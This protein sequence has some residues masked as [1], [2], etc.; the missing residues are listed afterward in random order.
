MKRIAI[1]LGH[2]AQFHMFKYVT[3]YLEQQ[4]IEVD[5]LVK[6]KDILEE[7]VRNSGRNYYIVR[8][9]ERS[10]KGK[11]RL[12]LALLGMEL[13][14]I[15]Y[16]IRRRPSLLVGTYAPVI[17][18]LT[19]TRMIICCEDDT[20]VV[21][22]FAKTSYPYADA[23][24]SP[25]Y[26]D[27]GKWD[28]K[29]TKYYGFQKLAYLHPN[30]FTPDST[31]LSKYN[32]PER[33]V[34]IRLARLSAHHDAGI[35]GLNLDLVQNM[36][37]TAKQYGYNVY[38]TSEAN[39]DPSLQPYKLDIDYQDIHHI[40]A[41][42][43][44]LVSDSQSMSVEASM[45]GVPSVRFSDFAGRISVLEVLEQ[46]YQLTFGVPTDNPEQLL[47]KVNSLLSDTTLDETFH[48]NREKM[49]NDHID[50]TAFFSWFIENYP[51]SRKTMKEN[52]DY[53]W[54]FR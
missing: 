23:I 6:R 34:L 27:G 14:V 10:S 42:A 49:L 39:L 48:K 20:A 11:L 54:R 30:W 5:Y 24:L 1:F 51:E 2:P 45:L 47:E 15:V 44:L 3:A 22:R 36:I 43:G 46:K 37:S 21:P 19:G 32:L 26:C 9:K 7:L 17:S 53:Q 28:L 16:I 50:V 25:M 29:M 41:F 13:K 8:K 4:G 38:I 18:H 12:I 40:L 35:K 31:I 33:F 52:P